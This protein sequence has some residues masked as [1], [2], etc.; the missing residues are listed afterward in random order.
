MRLYVETVFA[1][2]A[3]ERDSRHGKPS[4]PL[5]LME[6]FRSIIVD[7]VV[8]TCI[9]KQMLTRNDLRKGSARFAI[10]RKPAAKLLTSLVVE[11]TLRIIARMG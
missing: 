9:N 3:G 10:S 7:A 6:E 1:G 4:L 2:S 8:L 11:K 5:D